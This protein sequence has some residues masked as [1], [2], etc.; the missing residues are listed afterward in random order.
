[1]TVSCSG[2]KNPTA[3]DG[4]DGLCTN[5]KGCPEGH[6]S[7]GSGFPI[8]ASSIPVGTRFSVEKSS[9]LYLCGADDSRNCSTPRKVWLQL[10]RSGGKGCP[11]R[12]SIAKMLKAIH[13]QENKKAA[14][15]KAKA[16][17]AQLKEMKLKEAARKVEDNIEETLTY[18]DFPYEHWARIRTNNVI[19]RLNREIRRRTRV[20]GTFPDGNSALMLV[21]ARLRHV[22][23]TQWG[24]KKYMNMKHLEAALEDVSIAG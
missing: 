5:I 20:V 6:S 14:R 1:M 2:R 12:G 15:E 9:V 18:C 24:N 7:F 11:L 22:A 19:E 4:I 13:A 17:V 21:C 8:G 10:R 23:G 16:V 3:P